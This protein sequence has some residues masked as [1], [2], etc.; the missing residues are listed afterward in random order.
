MVQLTINARRYTVDAEPDTPL[1]FVLRDSLGLTGTKYGCGIGQC[2]ACTVLLDGAATRSCQIPLESVGDQ[3]IT[4]IEAI[5]QDPVGARVV[6]AWVGIEVPQCGY[7]QSGQ[8]MAAT[9]LLKQTPKPTEAD[10]AGAMTNLCRCGTYNA[11]AAAVRQA[12]A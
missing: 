1:L 2:G 3:A 9:S 8:V 12:A 11:I 5:E 6:A 10:I 4:T 7:C